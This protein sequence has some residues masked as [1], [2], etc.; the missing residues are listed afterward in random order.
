VKRFSR[1]KRASASPRNCVKTKIEL[2]Q[3]VASMPGFLKPRSLA[4]KAG[5]K[6]LIFCI[7]RRRL[8]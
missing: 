7:T 1:E 2:F 5:L 8:K 6:L 4:A 3:V